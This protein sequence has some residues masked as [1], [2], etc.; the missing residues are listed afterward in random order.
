MNPPS[1]FAVRAERGFTLIEL[2][3]AVTIGLLLT[4]VVASLFIHS[5]S[6]Y[7]ATDE[8]SRMQENIRHTNHLL[9]RMVHHAGY[10][11]TPNAY[12][13]VEQAPANTAPLVV[14][15]AVVNPVFTGVEGVGLAADGFANPDSFTVRFQ[16]SGN[17]TGTPDGTVTDCQG[18]EID[19][20]QFSA[21]RFFIQ[22]GANGGNALWCNNGV[23]DAELVPD[24]ENMQ[25][26]LGEDTVH[27]QDGSSRRDRSTDR[28][29][30]IADV[31]LA[32]NMN[33]VMSVRVALLFRTPNI[34]ATVVPEAK[35][36]YNLNGVVVGPY[37]DKRIR[38][39]VA[40]SLNVRNRSY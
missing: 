7:G 35:R 26:L 30:P 16:G 15:D 17:G 13:D 19:S 3:I 32:G 14:Y 36:T 25:L 4:V 22:A 6:T 1:L 28:Y 38:R 37:N 9:A 10:M 33:K 34:A 20:G 23:G 5:R 2:M 40:M 27:W 8:L 11:S 31:L 24:V 12:R 39:A 21:N 29:L 18:R